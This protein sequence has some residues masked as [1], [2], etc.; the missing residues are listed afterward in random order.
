[1]FRW[2]KRLFCGKKPVEKKVLEKIK[3]VR[4]LRKKVAKK[5]KK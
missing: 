3:K 2:L 1:M 4:K 5:S